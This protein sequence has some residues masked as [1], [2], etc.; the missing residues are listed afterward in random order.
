VS[1]SAGEWVTSHRLRPVGSER[2]LSAPSDL[3]RLTAPVPRR[4]AEGRVHLFGLPDA[5]N[6]VCG[7]LAVD[8]P[9]EA[10]ELIEDREVECSSCLAAVP[11]RS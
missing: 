11:A 6:A 7:A 2:A 9:H 4:G 10:R 1:H 3:P 8:R 5:R